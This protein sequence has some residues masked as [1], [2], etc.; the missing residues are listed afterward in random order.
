[1][2]RYVEH[3]R[4]STASNDIFPSVAL[5]F[6]DTV[7]AVREETVKVRL[8]LCVVVSVELVLPLSLMVH[9]SMVLLAPKLNGNILNNQL[10]KYLAK[11][12][13]DQVVCL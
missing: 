13:M 2:N 6:T 8:C 10:L 3:I 9:Q 4:T 1:M 11:S 5:G 12:Q 7:Q